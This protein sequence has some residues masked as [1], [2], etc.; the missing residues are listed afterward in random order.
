MI[1]VES[2]VYTLCVTALETEFPTINV[3]SEYVRQPATFPHV[4]IVEMDNYTDTR[5]ADNSLEDRFADIVYQVDI[6]STKDYGKKSECRKIAN[7]I[8][9]A[10]IGFGFIRLSLQ[11]LQ[12]L[13]DGTIYRITGRYRAIVDELERIH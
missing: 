12:N 6:Y 3:A 9:Q 8:D 13:E 2:Q 4:S 5:S 10:L 7:I 11:P 1:D